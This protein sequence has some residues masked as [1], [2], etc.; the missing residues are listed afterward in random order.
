VVSNEEIKRMLDAKRRGINTDNVKTSSEKNKICSKCK[1]KNPEKAL[2]C[3]NCG[4]KLD[5]NSEIKCPTCGKENLNNSKFCVG[6]GEQLSKE[7]IGANTNKINPILESRD[8]IPK[9]DVEFIE[10]REQS[11]QSDIPGKSEIKENSPKKTCPSCNG[12]NLAN[13]K[14]CVVCGKNFD[15]ESKTQIKD[16]I[17]ETKDL[18]TTIPEIKVPNNL[19]EKKVYEN[20]D[21]TGLEKSTEYIDPVEKIKKSKEL[22]DMGAI[23]SEEFESI[24]KKYLEQI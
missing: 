24:K 1:T 19:L 11:K 3:V 12:K 14:F 21:N 6:C 17:E 18:N 16:S 4:N 2:F 10:S 13:A 20:K 8:N 23:T 9:N 7:K 15:Q 22:L 5:Q